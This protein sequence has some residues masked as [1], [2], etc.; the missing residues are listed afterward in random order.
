MLNKRPIS[1][2]ALELTYKKW[3]LKDK[4]LSTSRPRSLIC[5]VEGIGK[6]SM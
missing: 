3:V 2:Q 5:S 6:P 4:S 1:L